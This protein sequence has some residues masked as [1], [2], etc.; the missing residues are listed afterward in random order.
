MRNGLETQTAGEVKIFIMNYFH[1]GIIGA[2]ELSIL[3][4]HYQTEISAFDTQTK[5]MVC[6]EIS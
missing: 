4:E 6:H 1:F 5:R 3:S 2:I